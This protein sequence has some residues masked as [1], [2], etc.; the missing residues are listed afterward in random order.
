MDRAR[1][2][3]WLEQGILGLVTL[4][5]IVGP[6]IF[7][8]AM[9]YDFMLVQGLTALALVLWCARFW[10]RADYRMLWPPF[11]WAIVAFLLYAIWQYS[12]A[13][14][15]FAARL[16]FNRIIVYA[17][18]FFIILD[19]FNKQE[20]TQILVFTLVF[21]GMAVA[22]YAIYQF[23]TG[24]RTIFGEPQPAMY[25]GRAG[26]PFVCPNHLADYLAMVLPLAFGLTLMARLNTVLKVFLCYA[27][28]V[29]LGGLFVTLSR[30]GC[31]AAGVGLLVLFGVLIFNRD[32]RLQAIIALALILIPMIWLGAKSIRAQNRMNKGFSAGTFSDDRFHI[33]PSAVTLWRENFWT[34]VG[35]NHFDLRFRELRPPLTQ[36]QARPNRVHNDYLNTLVDWGF[37]GFSLVAAAWGVFWLGVVRI[38]RFVRR[39]NDFGSRQSTRASIVLGS[40]AGLAALMVHSIAE[41]NIHIPG[42]AVT[43]VALL[44]VVTGHWRFATERFW[45]RPGVVGRFIAT[46]LCLTTVGWLAINTSRSTREQSNLMDADK[47]PE[48]DERHLAHLL[49]AY[50]AD[51]ANPWTPYRIGEVLRKQSWIGSD[52]WEKQAQEAIG[53]FDKSIALDPYDPHP[54]LGKGMSLHWLGRHEEAWPHFRKSMLL[55]PNSYYVRAHY[56]WHFLQL[57]AWEP[58]VKWFRNSLFIKPTEN[59]IAEAYYE[60]AQRKLA[61]ER[62]GPALSA[63]DSSPSPN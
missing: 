35:P 50:Q 31:A 8:S 30:A 27:G 10:V 1:L 20:W 22:M 19:N 49:Q 29:M 28:I 33:W 45:V 36:L 15:E 37:I 42:L 16:D 59:P 54:L 38:W 48:M 14:V 56:G 55:D 5:L 46:A 34:G 13:E 57:R 12:R 43:V 2:D 3:S 21:T 17:A 9:L 52:G 63:P 40:C 11:A 39:A 53:W 4:I 6:F 7:G 58:A 23:A 47:F 62:V 25:Y 24:S 26:G 18:L 61:D 60:I 44:A 32:F 41:F 51:P